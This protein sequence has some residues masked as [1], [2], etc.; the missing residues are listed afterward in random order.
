VKACNNHGLWNETGAAFAFVVEPHFYETWLF[1]GLC[2]V[3]VAVSG[4]LIQ[5]WRL[6]LQRRILRL[7][8]LHALDNERARIAHDIHDDLGSRLSQLSVLGELAGRHLASPAQAQPHLEKLRATTGEVFQALDK[9]VWA[10]NPKQDSVAGLMTYLRE[11][12]PEFLSPAG[13]HC[14]L[15]FPSPASDDPLDSEK[16][17]HL[18]LVVKEALNN[19]VKHARATEVWLRLSLKDKTLSLTIQDNGRGIASPQPSTLNPQP[20]GMGNG[21]VNMR[22]RLARLGG[23]FTLHSNP[24]QGTRIELTLPL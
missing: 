11:F 18:F 5:A 20:P 24:G 13:I 7:E 2:L 22:E 4:G 15:D 19:V 12:G 23:Q 10:V 8:H 17:H 9:I 16:R 6:R 3:F 1:Y 14:R 21:L